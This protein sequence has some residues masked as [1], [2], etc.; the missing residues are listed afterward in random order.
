MKSTITKLFALALIIFLYSCSTENV[1]P[2]GAEASNNDIPSIAGS[3]SVHPAIDPEC[4]GRVSYTLMEETTGSTDVNYFGP[5]GINPGTSTPWGDVTI[6]NSDQDLFLEITMAF[7]WYV[8]EADVYTGPA[9]ELAL[10]NNLPKKQGGDW[11]NRAVSP[12]VNAYQVKIPFSDINS[13][14][15]SCFAWA[16]NIT[17]VKLDFFSGE[18]P[19]ST[20]KLWVKNED[21][22]NTATPEAN[23]ANPAIANWCLG[24]CGPVITTTTGGNCQGCQS[25]NTVEI[26]DCE[27]V[28]VTSCKDLSN[29]VLLFTD[30]TFQKYDGLSAK[31]GTFKGTGANDGKEIARVYVKSGCYQSGDGPGWGRRFDS[32]CNDDNTISVPGTGGGGNGNGGN[33]N[34]GNGNG[35]GGGNGNGKGKNK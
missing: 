28:D 21:W 24:S 19:A 17:V 10:E 32:P 30:N 31:T 7:G 2:N 1:N 35:N 15:Q 18:D 3:A 11:S 25:E 4:S 14:S 13:N 9:G 23:S 22:N 29:V 5:F 6:V 20:T 26:S 33:G 16:C 27:S 12:I 8:K 34:G